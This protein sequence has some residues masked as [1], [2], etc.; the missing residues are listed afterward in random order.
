MIKRKLYFIAFLLLISSTVGGQTFDNFEEEF[1]EEE[2]IRLVSSIYNVH[3]T[4]FNLSM[5]HE[6]RLGD[7]TSL[8]TE[9][10]FYLGDMYAQAFTLKKTGIIPSISIEARW[11][12]NRIRRACLDKALYNNA[13]NYFGLRV[14][15]FLGKSLFSHNFSEFTTVYVT[16]IYGL[17]RNFTAH[18]RFSYEL[19]VGINVE[20][21]PLNR[22]NR[23]N[24]TDSY[25]YFRVGVNY[26]L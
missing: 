15:Y 7:F 12:Y 8:K 1:N 3:A 18:S 16:P 22:Y 14:G 5:S 21:S 20:Y 4:L 26:R 19:G 6:F 23:S 13:G 10:I 11:Y 9:F 25:F 24:E 2:D 17:K